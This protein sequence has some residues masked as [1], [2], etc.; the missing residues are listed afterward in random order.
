MRQKNRRQEIFSESWKGRS[1]EL[2]QL[3]SFFAFAHQKE[4]LELRERQNE[5]MQELRSHFLR[6]FP[7]FRDWLSAQ[8]REDAYQIYC[9]PGELLLSPEQSGVR[10]PQISRDIKHFRKVKF[11]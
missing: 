7:S 9:Y 4:Q 6:R 3:R 2:N 8:S 1:A 5:E 10:I 11:L